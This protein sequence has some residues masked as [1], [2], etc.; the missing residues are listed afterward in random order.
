MHRT[1]KFALQLLKQQL[2]EQKN[3]KSLFQILALK[4]VIM[5]VKENKERLNF[6]VAHHLLDCVVDVHLLWQNIQIIQ[7]NIDTTR[8]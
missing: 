7:T 4:Y 5:S 1:V 2:K 3:G 6:N 8:Q